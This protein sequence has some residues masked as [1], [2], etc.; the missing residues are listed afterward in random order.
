LRSDEKYT[1]M[2]MDALPRFE[3]A[4]ARHPQKAGIIL[5]IKQAFFDGVKYRDGVKSIDIYRAVLD[6]NVNSVEE[7]RKYLGA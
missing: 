2:A 1:G 3:A 5:E 6:E 7:F 4:L